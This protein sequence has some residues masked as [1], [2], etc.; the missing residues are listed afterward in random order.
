M[1]NFLKALGFFIPALVFVLVAVYLSSLLVKH[2]T[3]GNNP[4][5]TKAAI[6]CPPDFPSYSELAQKP[7]HTV[8][9][10]P[11]EKTMFAKDGDFVN[12]QVIITKSETEKSKVACGYL[13]VIAGTK[14]GGSLKSWEHLYINP[15]GFGGHINPANQIGPGD[16]NDYSEYVFSLNKISYWKGLTEYSQNSLSS[17][18][19]AAL[20]NVSEQ[21][22]FNIGLSTEN[23]TGFIKEV[24]ISYKCWDPTTGEEND[25]CKLN[26][27]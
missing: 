12:S 1:K 14:Q 16:G 17:A 7:G 5:G 8:P 24:S 22:S 4:S 11:I 6:S 3:I 13:H 26:V 25:G 27:K 10:I 18:D 23:Q 15:N 9:L 21:V 19:W 20:L 2:P